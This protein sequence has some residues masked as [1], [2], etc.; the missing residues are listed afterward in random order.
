[1]LKVGLL[2]RLEAKPGKEEQVAT[3]LEQGLELANAERTT[4]VW[5]AVRSGDRSFAIF[6]SFADEGG[7]NTH[8]TGPIAKALMEQAPT[9]L[10]SAPAIERVDVIG[11]KVTA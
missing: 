6:D 4:P 10:A 1:M 3:F 5:F 8:L 2:V 11:A 9:L 7:R